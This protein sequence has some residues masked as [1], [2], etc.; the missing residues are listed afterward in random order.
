MFKRLRTLFK[1]L[2]LFDKILII[3]AAIGISTFA[4]IFFRKS[5]YLTV[6]LR[7]GQESIYYSFWA[8]NSNDTSGVSSSTQN[9][10]YKGMSE[11]D[12]L[13]RVMAEVL[14]LNSYN[15]VSNRST[16]FLKTRLKT[17]YSRS[18]N[19]YSYKGTPVLIGSKVTLYLDDV[20][21]EALVVDIEG[22]KDMPEKKLLKVN[23][24]LFNQNSTFLETSGVEQYLADAIQA[25]D[26]VKDLQGNTIIKILDKTV[27]PANKTIVTSDGKVFISTDPVRKDVFLTMEIL[28]DVN[29]EKYFLFNDVPILVGEGLPVCTKVICL[30]PTITAI[31][32]VQ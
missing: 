12:G 8:S 16:L 32:N 23:S 27:K 21:V 19:Q 6:T 22:I 29:Q 30:Y 26:T 25:G 14:G 11:K 5:S 10:F 18:N 28:A 15:I 7:V 9:F 31:E 20:S 1:K 13:G 4:I 17:T 24:Q 2:T 3:A